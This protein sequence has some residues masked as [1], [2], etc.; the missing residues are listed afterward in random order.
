MKKGKKALT[1][2]MPITCKRTKTVTAEDGTEQA[3]E[4]AFRHF[5]LTRMDSALSS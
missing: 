2:C 3:E 5:Q 4:F 1:L